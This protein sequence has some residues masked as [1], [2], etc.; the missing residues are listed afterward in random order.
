MTMKIY[1]YFTWN[2]MLDDIILYPMVALQEVDYLNSQWRNEW[3]KEGKKER[4]NEWMNEW[5]NSDGLLSYCSHFSGCDYCSH[6][7]NTS[8][9]I[10]LYFNGYPHTKFHIYSPSGLLNIRLTVWKTISH[11]CHIIIITHSMGMIACTKLSHFFK[12]P[13]SYI[14]HYSSLTHTAHAA[15]VS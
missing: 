4:M 8:H 5:M 7:S 10:F 13:L 11:I 15:P 14:H 12:D 3:T 6:K 1:I 9:T 2:D